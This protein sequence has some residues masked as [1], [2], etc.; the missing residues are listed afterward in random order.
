MPWFVSICWL[1]VTTIVCLMPEKELAKY[2]PYKEIALQYVRKK[3]QKE[4]EFL[5]FPI[6]G[7][8]QLRSKFFQ[9][10]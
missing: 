5:S 4:V 8:V 1:G 6:E 10:P 3:K 7:V 9:A 2:S